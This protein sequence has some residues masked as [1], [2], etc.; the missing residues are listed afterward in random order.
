MQL[1]ENPIETDDETLIGEHCHIVAQSFDGPR[2]D[3]PLPMNR[4]NK[5]ENLI[6]L[7]RNCHKLID[8]QPACYTVPVLH[9]MKANHEKWVRESL[10]TY[11]PQIQ[12]ADEYYAD[13]IDEWEKRAQLDDWLNWSSWVLGPDP[14][15]SK[16]L[17]KDLADLKRWQLTRVWPEKRKTLEDSFHNFFFVL[18][19]FQ[20][21]FHK[22]SVE[23]DS[24]YVTERFYKNLIDWDENLHSKLVYEHEYH[25]GLVQ[26]LM[27]ELTRAANLICDRV[28]ETISRTYRL[29]KGRL[30]VQS[31]PFFDFSFKEFVVTYSNQEKR[32]RIPYEGLSDFE[33]KRSKRDYVIGP[34]PK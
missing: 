18:D 21:V 22:H 28:R 17:N 30:I 33:T 25:V 19:D 15:I 13:I 2:G 6:L 14:M 27:L 5:Y 31:G 24:N 29:A 3:N 10:S 20:K 23:K 16:E 12:R 1:F 4:R 8:D 32:R 11:D 7:C 26:D 34:T 9:D